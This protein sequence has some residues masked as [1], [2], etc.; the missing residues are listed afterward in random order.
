MGRHR[1]RAFRP[2]VLLV[3][4]A[5]TVVV[6]TAGALVAGT[7]YVAAGTGP[8]AGT[9]SR[10]APDDDVGGLVGLDAR[11]TAVLRW[12]DAARAEAYADGDAEAL[13]SLY[14]PGSALAR[15]DLAVLAAY[16]ERGLRVRGPGFEVH[17]VEV[18]ESDADGLVL[19]VRD[20]LLRADVHDVTGA[21]VASLPGTDLRERVLE[22]ERD[23]PRWVL[24]SA[25]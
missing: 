5:L 14:P 9:G 11:G 10:G 1:A 22:L 18:L 21:V 4:A 12:W 24:V 25:S 19:R 13:A 16:D 17:E 23:G 2:P 8:A 6:L 20:R 7:A 15:A 3:A